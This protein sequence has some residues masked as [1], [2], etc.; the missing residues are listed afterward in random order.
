MRRQLAAVAAIVLAGSGLVGVATAAPAAGNDLVVDLGNSTGRFYG[1][2]AG[3]LYGLYDQDVPT[4]NLIEGM[5][6]RTTDTKA[7]DGQQHPGSDALEVAQPFTDSG[8][9]DLYIYMTDVYRNF[10]YERTSYD[11]YKGY[12]RTQVEQILTSPYADRIVLVPYNEP[13][14]NWFAGDLD[15]FNQEWNETYHYLKSLWPQARIAGPNY[16]HWLPDDMATF[17]TYCQANGCLPDVVTWHELSTPASVRSDVAAYRSLESSLGLDIPAN[18][19]EYAFRYQLTNPAQMVG[20]LSALEDSKVDGALAYWNINGSLGDS[21]SQQNVPN[22][23][24]WLYHWYSSM[25][26]DTV[27]VT[28]PQGNAADSL[29]GLASLDT[30]QRQARIVLGG[31]PPGPSTVVVKHVD[32]ALFG[33]TVH[34]TLEQDPWSG[35]TGA[36][37]QPTRLMDTDVT[38]GA[39]GSIRV[40]VDLA[41][42]TGDTSTCTATGDRVTGEL[43][44]AVSLCGNGE[45]VD[46]PSGIVSGLHD[47]TISA[48]VNPSENSTWSRVFDFGTGTNTNMFLTLDAGGSGLRFA[49]TN[50]GNGNEQRITSSAGTLPTDR[51]SHVAVTLSGTTGTLYVDGEAVGTNDGMTLDPAALGT[52][53]QNYIGKSQYNDPYLSGAVDDFQIYDRA[54]SASEVAD[55]A[56]GAQGAGDVASYRFDEASGTTATDSSG[57]GADATIVSDPAKPPSTSAYQIVLSPGGTGSDTPADATWTGSYEAEQATIT[58]DGWNINTEGTAS[59]LS[60]FATS[61]N[62]DVGGLRTGSSTVITFH[63]DVP[64]TGDYRLKVFDGSYAHDSDVDGPTN[65]Y[66]RVDGGDPHEVWLPAGYE[67]PVWNYGTSTLHLTAG[68]HTVALS[69]V[70]ADGAAT[71]GDA[72]IDKIDLQ[73]LGPAGTVYEAEQADLSGGARVDYA[74]RGQSGAGAVTMTRGQATTFWVYA[75]HDGYTDLSFRYS[76]SGSADVSVDTGLAAQPVDS[77]LAGGGHWTT[78]TYRLYLGRGV[79]KVTVTGHAGSTTL[80]ELTA[81]PDGALPASVTYQAEDAALTGT[82]TVDNEYSQAHGGVVTGVSDGAANAMTLTVHAATAGRYAMTVRFAN[83]EE[84]QATHYNPDLMTRP[85]DISVDGAPTFHVN[86]ANTFSFNQFWTLTVPVSLHRGTNT[87]RFTANQQYNYDGTTVG[88]VYS[89][90]GIGAPLRSDTAPN[91]D[92]ITLS[93]FQLH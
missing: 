25:T 91:L 39:D 56:G 54:L 45:Y 58:G 82:A 34:V 50:S 35:M 74:S 72:I 73:R 69:T 67:W 83:D 86:F 85:A 80:D 16:T 37:S 61:G 27:Q 9:R 7:Q 78:R 11:Q 6:L 57:N 88:V 22:A 38:V 46:L 48:W 62:Q 77:P 51:W 81:T 31:G 59:N 28:A 43:G 5:G 47:Y 4:D 65:V 92:D 52:T 13:D 3:A 76:G 66:A 10:P 84:M 87:I 12:L 63:V 53:T 29:Q 15:A 32:P 8:G 41:G 49:I 79:N 40:P 60:G 75:D 30:A 42:P 1:G 21:V 17:L 26:G 36:A 90:D 18:T 20:W 23:Q 55:L 14:G 68:A 19:N 2:A 64:A 24:W 70:G 33:R 93:P 44:N 89:G 71:H